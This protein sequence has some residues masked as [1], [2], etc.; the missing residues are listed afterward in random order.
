MNLPTSATVST[1]SSKFFST[2]VAAGLLCGAMDL[3]AAFITWVPQGVPAR[4]ILQGIASGLLGMPAFRGGFAIAALGLGL[5]F[6]IAIVAAAVFYTASRKLSWLVRRPYIA[7]ILYGVAVYVVMYWL[8]QP[9]SRFHR[10]RFSVA[11]TIIAILTHIVCVGLPIAL[12]V[13]YRSIHR[14]PGA[15]S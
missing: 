2:I 10:G 13:H 14:V 4:M 5:H 9:L 6:F 12:V 15:S 1:D 8:V 3:I 11:H 7:G